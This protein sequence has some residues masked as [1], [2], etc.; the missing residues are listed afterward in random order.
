M[1]EDIVRSFRA[2]AEA[3]AFTPE[4]Y[5]QFNKDI[6]SEIE[7]RLKYSRSAQDTET[8]LRLAELKLEVN[9][10]FYWKSQA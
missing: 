2:V 5:D 3:L 9:R 4:E 1:T 7:N 10:D 6:Q 8:A